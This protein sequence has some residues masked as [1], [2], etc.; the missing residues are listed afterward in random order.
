MAEVHPGLKLTGPGGGGG[1]GGDLR[2][3]DHVVDV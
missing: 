1:G 2:E 3:R